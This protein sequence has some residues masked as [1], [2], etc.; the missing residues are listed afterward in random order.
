MFSPDWLVP[1]NIHAV[2]TTRQEGNLALHVGADVDRALTNRMRFG[3]T[4]GDLDTQPVWL[5][6]VH[7]NRVL[8]VDCIPVSPPETAAPDADA[9]YTTLERVP[10][11]IMVADCLPLLLAS[12]DGIEI[13]A[14]HAGWRGLANQVIGATLKTF[15]SKD[16]VAWLGPAIGPCHYEIDHVV[17]SAFRSETGFRRVEGSDGE[18]WMMNLAEVAKEQLAEQGVTDVTGGDICTWCDDRFYSH[19]QDTLRSYPAARFAAFVWKS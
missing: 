18:H 8:E 10:L 7:G 16:V 3:Q 1:G 11:V 5:N 17:H 14:V 15:R 12:R 4:L 9:A 2:V 19:R 6:Q 13:A